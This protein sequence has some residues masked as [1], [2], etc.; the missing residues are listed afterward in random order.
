MTIRLTLA[1]VI[2]ALTVSPALCSERT[3]GRANSDRPNPS[4]QGRFSRPSS[5]WAT[6]Q[7][8]PERLTAEQEKKL[9][10]AL[11][12]KRPEH[13][14]RLKQL[15]EKDPQRYRRMLQMMWRWYERW[16]NQ[17]KEIRD[18]G[19]AA[20]DSRVKLWRLAR[21]LGQATNEKDRDKII[22]RLRE[23]L[24]RQFDAE[25]KVCAHRLEQLERQL[26]KM[27]ERLRRDAK[28]RNKIIEQRL[29]QIRRKA[30]NQSPE[31]HR[32]KKD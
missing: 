19:I 30:K 32:L 26:K 20:M 27:Q 21:R 1:A 11:K 31:H 29:K 24:A 7:G 9:L 17:P 6:T 10:A 22:A 25:Q 15:Q 4:R 8:Q 28:N 2:L 14:S 18:K 16:E 5:P 23:E 12:D 13:Y 3:E